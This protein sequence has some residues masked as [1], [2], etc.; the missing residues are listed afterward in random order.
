MEGFS[1]KEL[2]EQQFHQVLEE[3]FSLK[4]IKRFQETGEIEVMQRFF[5]S[6]FLRGV[7]CTTT[8]IMGIISGNKQEDE[9]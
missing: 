5:E 2:Q 7:S 3:N 4:Q 6:G 9:K 1:S 8:H